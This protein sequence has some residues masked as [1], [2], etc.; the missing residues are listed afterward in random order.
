MVHMMAFA[1]S[2]SLFVLLML[3]LHSNSFVYPD[4]SLD[5]EK[6]SEGD[7]VAEEMEATSDNNGKN[8]HGYNR[9]L[10]HI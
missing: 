7:E 5:D 2:S 4:K 8:S 1:G 6:R 3:V 10:S 9:G